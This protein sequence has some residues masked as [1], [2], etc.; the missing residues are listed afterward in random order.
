MRAGCLSTEDQDKLGLVF[1]GAEAKE[2][3]LPQY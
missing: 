2:S 3:R 1:G